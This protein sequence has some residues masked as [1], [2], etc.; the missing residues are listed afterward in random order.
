M[1]DMVACC[2]PDAVA[3]Q[4]RDEVMPVGLRRSGDLAEEQQGDVPGHIAE[5]LMSASRSRHLPE[6]FGR[7]CSE[8]A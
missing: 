7:R 4:R 8:L 1:S 3:E 6:R 2:Q 5:I